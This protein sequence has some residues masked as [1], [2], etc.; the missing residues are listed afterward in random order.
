MTVN[1]DLGISNMLSIQQRGE[2][3]ATGAAPAIGRW[4]GHMVAAEMVKAAL[5]TSDKGNRPRTGAELDRCR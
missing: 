3:L 1:V 5:S 2:I 4:H